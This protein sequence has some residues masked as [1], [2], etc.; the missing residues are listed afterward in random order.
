M[1]EAPRSVSQLYSAAP[2]LREA[3]RR[4]A[5]K[6]REVVGGQAGALYLTVREFAV[7]HSQDSKVE[8]LGTDNLGNNVA[9]VVRNP[10][11]G[12]TLL[13]HVDRLTNE[14]LE[15]MTAALAG[16]QYQACTSRLQ[17]SIVGAFQDSKNVSQ[18]LLI[19]ILGKQTLNSIQKRTI[20]S[21]QKFENP[22]LPPILETINLAI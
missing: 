3:A 22:E 7:S 9:L 14:C 4:L 5:D 20:L 15:S 12:S 11:T 2:Q 6:R 19:P 8:M 16:Q 21:L 10:G 13:A 1:E 18:S 17:L